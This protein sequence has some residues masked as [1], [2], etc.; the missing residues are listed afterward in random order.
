MPTVHS[1]CAHSPFV[2]CLESICVMPVVRPDCACGWF[3][4]CLWFVIVVFLSQSNTAKR[5]CVP[6]C[7]LSL[8]RPSPRRPFVFN[9]H[10]AWVFRFSTGIFFIIAWSFFFDHKVHK[11]NRKVPQRKSFGFRVA[12][13]SSNLQIFS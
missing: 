12:G 11:V 4:L 8:H 3:G 6:G 9:Y 5:L 1:C 10:R 13:K 2:L 7:G